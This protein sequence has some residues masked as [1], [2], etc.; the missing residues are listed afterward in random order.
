M[1]EYRAY[2]VGLDGHFLSFEPLICSDDAEAVT[3]AKR[4]V[5]GHD[6]EVWSGERFV[7]RLESNAK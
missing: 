6:I 3:E 4:L 5:D 7:A 2:T 1:A